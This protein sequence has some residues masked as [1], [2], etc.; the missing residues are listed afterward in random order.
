[1]PSF[2]FDNAWSIRKRALLAMSV[3]SLAWSQPGLQRASVIVVALISANWEE[4]V[5]R[6]RRESLDRRP[7]RDVLDVRAESPRRA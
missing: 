6:E 7:A 4:P 3:R 5:G 2:R 1:M